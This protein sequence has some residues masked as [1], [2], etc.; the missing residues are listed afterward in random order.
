MQ[1]PKITYT[2]RVT[3]SSIEEKKKKKNNKQENTF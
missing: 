1:K 2:M 3:Q